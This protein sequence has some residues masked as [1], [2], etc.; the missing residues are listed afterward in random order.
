M[1]KTDA[2]DVPGLAAQAAEVLAAC[3]PRSRL[4]FD[5]D[6]RRYVVTDVRIIGKRHPY[7]DVQPLEDFEQTPLALQ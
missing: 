1:E 2:R 4:R 7:L 5:L 6:G 3:D